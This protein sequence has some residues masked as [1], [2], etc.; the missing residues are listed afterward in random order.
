MVKANQTKDRARTVLRDEI[1]KL[2]EALPP[3]KQSEAI[4]FLET[5]STRSPFD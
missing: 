5:S 2:Y 3:E 1:I 4:R